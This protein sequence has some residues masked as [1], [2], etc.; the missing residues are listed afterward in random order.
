MNGK[1]QNKPESVDEA[2]LDRLLSENPP[3]AAPDWFEARLMARI[4]AEV[5]APSQRSW[6]R[7]FN[8]T[9]VLA[10]GALA[11]A[12]LLAVTQWNGQPSGSE[13]ELS[14]KMLNEALDAL[15]SYQQES[16]QWSYEIF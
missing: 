5:P 15:V 7:Q 16:D 8:F 12:I 10:F 2:M 3:P 11:G 4:R 1:S 9:R 14:Q 13:P 6:L